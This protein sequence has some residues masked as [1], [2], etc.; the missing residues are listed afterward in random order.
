MKPPPFP[1]GPSGDG[2][3]PGAAVLGWP[4]AHSLSPLLHGFWLRRMRL[5]GRYD[6]LPVPP[7]ALAATLRRLPGEGFR[8]VN[9]TLPHK[10]AAFALCDRPDAAARRT[11]GLNTLVFGS[12][13]A[14]SGLNSDCPGFRDALLAS[15]KITPAATRRGAAVVLGAG[16]AARAVAVALEELGYAPVWLVNRGQ[17]RAERAAEEL[18][19]VAR[20][21]A[22]TRLP[23]LL[24]EA[25]ILVNATSL[26]MT[27]QPPL[28]LALDPLPRA[29]LVADIVYVPLHTPLLRRAMARG[30]PVMDGLDMLMHQ[31]VP[32]FTAW[33]DPPAPPRVTA[34]LRRTLLH[35]LGEG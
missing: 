10:E 12:D 17:A 4:V 14:I 22:L 3:V 21:A 16:G 34:E 8:G 32:G 19:G 25:A 9:L 35:A 33:F 5:P 2:R 27:G 20:A 13:G 15:G 31:A 1:E 23:A 30:N 7:D 26:G 29:A 28:D 6:A 24:E 11:G 18:G